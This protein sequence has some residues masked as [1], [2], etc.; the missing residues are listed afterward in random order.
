MRIVIRVNYMGKWNKFKIKK[1]TKMSKF[2]AAFAKRIGVDRGSLKWFLNLYAKCISEDQT[3]NMLKMEDNV[4]IYC[5]LRRGAGTRKKTHHER[6]LYLQQAQF[7]EQERKDLKEKKGLMKTKTTAAKRVTW[8]PE[9]TDK[10]LSS[11]LSQISSPSLDLEPVIEIITP[12]VNRIKFVYLNEAMRI[13]MKV[14]R[15]YSSSAFRYA[16]FRS[17]RRYKPGD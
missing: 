14:I 2:F 3:P 15:L 7:L 12:P 17:N 11:G 6:L 4:Q 8:D 16:M 1:S 5:I 9:I 10:N 13:F